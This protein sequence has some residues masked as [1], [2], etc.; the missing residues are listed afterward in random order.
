[1]KK[2]KTKKLINQKDKGIILGALLFSLLIYA[3]NPTLS[4]FADNI[5]EFE[6]SHFP[7][8]EDKKDLSTVEQIRIIAKKECGKRN[9]D[10][11]TCTNDLLGIAWTESRF[12]CQVI[13][14]NGASHGCYQIHQGYHKHITQAQA[15]DLEFASKWTLD[16]LIANKYV[17]NRDRAVMMHNGTPNT[18]KTLSYLASVNN[19]IKQK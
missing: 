13:G 9:I 17:I 15:E 2:T 3:I 19:Y 10:I 1:M 14:D 7:K 6:F 4:F 8:T 12:N 16:R 18:S 11:E 5:G